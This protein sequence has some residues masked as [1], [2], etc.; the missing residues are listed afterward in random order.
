MRKFDRREAY[1]L[2]LLLFYVLELKLGDDDMP[3][4]LNPFEVRS[5]LSKDGLDA[6]EPFALLTCCSS[7]WSYGRSSA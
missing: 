5:L 4:L 1:Y 7:G 2:I 6:S 3:I